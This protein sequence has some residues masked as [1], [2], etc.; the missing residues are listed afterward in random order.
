MTKVLRN[1]HGLNVL[2]LQE[3]VS[4]R[5]NLDQT[6]QRLGLVTT[7][8]PFQEVTRA[9]LDI[10]DLVFVDADEGGEPN[11][12]RIEAPDVP[13]IAIVGNEAPSRLSRI[14]RAR[15]ASHIQKPIR[16][17]GVYTA[18]LLAMNEHEQRIRIEKEIVTL[19]R[20]LSG[21]RIVVKAVLALM[22]RWEV[23]EDIAYQRLRN[24]AMRERIPVEEAAARELTDSG[25]EPPPNCNI[26]S[27]SSD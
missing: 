13:L 27:G 18:V 19:K 15:A 8:L 21:R 10:A 11:F 3:D 12:L 20:R 26:I 9:D 17:A 4:G 2:I 1:F 6:L 22:R 23:N 5:D 24:Y 14:V 25:R 16:S 7:V